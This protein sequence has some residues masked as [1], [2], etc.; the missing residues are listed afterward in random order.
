VNR[1]PVSGPLARNI[2]RSLPRGD[3]QREAAG[4]GAAVISVGG[5]APGEAKRAGYDAPV[6]ARLPWRCGDRELICGERTLVMG[7]LNVTPDSFSDGGRYLDPEAAVDRGLEMAADGADLID[8]GGE[9]TRPGAEPVPVDEEASRVVPVIKRLAAEAMVPI[10]IDTRHPEVAR[11]ALDA[12]ATVVNDVSGA[13]DPRMFEVA[14]AAH[15]GLVMMHMRGDPASMRD[16]TDYDDVVGEVHEHLRER[17]EAAVF[18]GLSADRLCVD[19]GI[20]FAKT[21]EQSLLLLRHVG[22]LFDLRVPV[23]VGP[24][25]KSFIGHVL[26]LDVGERLEGTEGAVAWCAAV[27]VHIVRVHDTREALRVVRVVDAIRTA[28]S[29]A[30]ASA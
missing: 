23:L 15:A 18:A 20:G 5:G 9:S 27:G 11:A 19:P 28:G 25:R 2:G 12:G 14:A 17:V 10:S 4:S 24:S 16:L 7:V 6:N 21:P 13:R 8:V 1:D 22:V 30:G 26:G 29:A 3:G